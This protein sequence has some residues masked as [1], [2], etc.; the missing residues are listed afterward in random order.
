MTII[1][2]VV[3]GLIVGY[4]FL[5]EQDKSNIR[6]DVKDQGAAITKIQ[7]IPCLRSEPCRDHILKALENKSNKTVTITGHGND[8]PATIQI[9]PGPRGPRGHDGERGPRGRRGRT[10]SQGPQGERGS[11]GDITAADINEI[12]Q[13]TIRQLLAPLCLD[14]TLG[15]LLTAL[16]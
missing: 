6:G 15:P 8:E 5:N 16:C 13:A 12:V 2:A 11:I 14:P 10:G 1:G 4:L 7:Q 9:I 3:G